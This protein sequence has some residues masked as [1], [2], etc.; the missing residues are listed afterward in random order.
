MWTYPDALT[1]V[2][3]VAAK[4]AFELKKLQRLIWIVLLSSV[5]WQY[6]TPKLGV[7]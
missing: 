4:N 1:F 2:T 5:A 6:S 7:Y 3:Q